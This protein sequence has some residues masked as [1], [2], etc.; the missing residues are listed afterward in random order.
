MAGMVRIRGI[1][2]PA[3]LAAGLIFGV[4]AH[5][6]L[7]HGVSAHAEEVPAGTIISAQNL[8]SLLDKTFEGDSIQSLIPEHFQW[9]IRK[10]GLTMKLAHSKPHPKDPKWVAATNR[11][12]E[13]VT[14]DNATNQVN[15]WVAGAPFPVVDPQEPK[16]G[17]KVMWNMYL[18]K[19]QGDNQEYPNTVVALINDKSGLERV[20]KQ[21]V[22]RVF[23]RGA[24]RRKN[25]EAAKGKRILEKTLTVLTSPQ[26]LKGNGLVLIRYVNGDPDWLL[27]YAVAARK[28]RRFSGDFW[29]DKLGSTDFLSDDLMVLSA[30]PTWYPDFK[31]IEKKKIL[32]VANTTK[33]FWQPKNGTP[34][35]QFPAFDLGKAPYWNPVD[36]WEPR[37]VYVVDATTPENHPYSRKVLYVDAE[38]W[39]PYLGEYFTPKGQLWKTTIQGYRVFPTQDDPDGKVLWPTWSVLFDFLAGHASI[40]MTD[41]NI[42]FN[43]DLQPAEINLKAVKRAKW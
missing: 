5:G 16:A 23:V 17:I 15:G 18:G 8:D 1:R 31:V 25:G 43:T 30:H 32:V 11:N 19:Q 39:T 28:V 20:Q 6:V 29:M 35:E 7:A 2:A 24:L 21:F 22:K 37:E 42:R 36:A 27:A 33:P 26:D 41:E 4:L 3:R 10:K 9:Q 34:K 12:I 40:L 38:L 14:L 13:A